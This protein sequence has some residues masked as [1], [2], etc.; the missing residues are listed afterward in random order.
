MERVCVKGYRF[1]GNMLK[2]I[3]AISMLLDHIG[4]VFFLDNI[5]LRIIGRIAFPIYAFMVSEGC[6]YTKSRLRYFLT[7]FLLGV[8]CQ[9]VFY[10]YSCDTYMG[11]LLTFSVSVLLIYAMQYVKD[12]M[13]EKKAGTSKKVSAI[14]IFVGAIVGVYFL[15]KILQMDYGFLGCMAPVFASLFR[16]PYRSHSGMWEKCDKHVIHVVLLGICLLLI[17]F[18]YGDIQVYSLLAIPILLLYSGKRGTLTMKYFFYIFYP[19]HLILLE[20]LLLFKE[21]AL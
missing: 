17:S 11:I 15:N 13:W 3:A 9:I 1:S 12:T 19:A 16:K 20:L 14:G 18:M 10:I 7:M 5:I 8:S 21:G 4:I 6:A 2:V